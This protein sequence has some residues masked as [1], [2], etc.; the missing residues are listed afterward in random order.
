M[1][2]GILVDFSVYLQLSYIVT[3]QELPVTRSKKCVIKSDFTIYCTLK[4]RK[5][6]TFLSFIVILC[7][8]ISSIVFVNF[9]F[10]NTYFIKLFFCFSF[11][12]CDQR[13]SL[14]GV[15]ILNNLIENT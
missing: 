9:F 4:S 14:V 3:T 15:I 7:F 5:V 2:T 11:I 12:K 8:E 10:S 6:C 1:S 13:V